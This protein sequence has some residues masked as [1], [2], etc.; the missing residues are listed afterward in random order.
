MG[1]RKQRIAFVFLCL[2]LSAFGAPWQPLRTACGEA[3]AVVLGT[4]EPVV[5]TDAQVLLSLTIDTVV[6]GPLAASSTVT[7]RWP[8]SL[9][10]A[11]MGP[12]NYRAL[13][14]L[15]NRPSAGWEIMTI[16]GPKTPIFA[17]GLALPPFGPGKNKSSGS[18]CYASV[19]AALGESAALVDQ[20]LVYFTAMETLLKEDADA[21]PDLPDF[22]AS[23]TAFARSPSVELKGLALASGVRRQDVKSLIQMA[24]DARGLSKSRATVPAS[25]AVLGWRRSDPEGLTALGTIAT[26]AEQ[27]LAWTAA[28]ALMMIH[29]KDAVPHLVKLLSKP[30]IQMRNAATRGLSMFVR[31]VPVLDGPNLRAMAYL[32][33][34]DNSGYADDLILPYVTMAP[35]APGREDEYVKAWLDWWSR[36]ASKWTK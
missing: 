3:D 14:F 23:V 21:D 11:R 26:E 15:R 5:M 16:G 31:G 17:S 8:G 28:E 9:T 18:V 20:S 4:V 13:W 32:A 12:P 2:T 19:W 7:V 10:A 1:Q 33:E 24:V 34:G 6:K 22:A 27:N 25:L 36:M 29:T 35:A 30:E